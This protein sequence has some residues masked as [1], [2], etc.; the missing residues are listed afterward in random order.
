MATI[1]FILLCHKDPEGII[2]QAQRLTAVGDYMSI[3][4]DARAKPAHYQKIREALKDNPNVTFSHKRAK[5]GWGEWS[6]VQATLYAVQTAIRDFP[7]ATHFYMLSGDCMS[8]K[9][10]EYAHAFL[11]REEVDYIESF[12]FF[13]S[14]WIKTGIKEERLIYRHYL[15]E[16]KHKFWFYKFLDWQRRLGLTREIPE[17]IQVQ[18][19]SQWWCLRRRTI[20]AV[21]EFCDTRDDVMR[22]FRTTWIPDET[23]FQT[24]VRHLVAEKELRTRT[25]T[26]LMFTD[27]GMPVT[28]YNDHYDLLLGQDFLFARKISPEAHEVKRRLGQLYAAKG[29]DFQISNEGRS[30]FRF[31]SGR[32]RVGRRFATRFWE[33]ESS[34]GRERE[35]MIVVCKKWHVAK[36][37]AQQIREKTDIV[38]LEYLFHEEDSA[39]PDLGGIQSTLEK[40]TRHRRALMRMLFD[41]YQT[42]RMVICLDPSGLD[43]LNDFCGDR[44]QT[45]L[46]EVECTFTD[47][48]L[49]G[50]AKRVELAGEQTSQDTLDRLLPTIRHDITFESDQIRDSEFE[51]HFRIRESRDAAENAPAL[52]RFLSIP[53]DTAKEIVALDHLFTD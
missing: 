35:L 41:Y 49:I 7:K 32:G 53:E 29:V 25:L 11:D 38:T 43:L 20:E 31:L 12:D 36:R 6:L 33:T 42:D 21:L 14:G 52:A 28:F 30:L 24:V 13:D 15:N 44:A 10:A 9:T 50:H 46:L 3:H 51:N 16:R 34:L 17:D 1:A 18:I 19:G 48:Y 27:Y 22:F 39:L 23:F 40:R 47:D 45:R 5:C 37:L 26:F 2:E 4:F 8:I